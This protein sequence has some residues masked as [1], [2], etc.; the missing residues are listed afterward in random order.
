MAG[1]IRDKDGPASTHG[2]LEINIMEAS[3]A[4]ALMPPIGAGRHWSFVAGSY[5]IPRHSGTRT[6]RNLSVSSDSAE[7]TLLPEFVGPGLGQLEVRNLSGKVS[8]FRYS[9]G[10]RLFTVPSSATT[11]VMHEML[12]EHFQPP[13][14]C[15]VFFPVAEGLGE[16]VEP[17]SYHVI[18]S[19]HALRTLEPGEVMEA[20]L[21]Y[22]RCYLCQDFR[23][24]VVDGSDPDAMP[25]EACSWMEWLCASCLMRTAVEGSGFFV[26]CVLCLAYPDDTLEGQRVRTQLSAL[27]PSQRAWLENFRR[28]LPEDY[29]DD[30]E[31]EEV[32]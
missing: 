19:P 17:C 25:C 29:K 9:S 2:F 6:S 20:G 3:G 5:S 27:S 31:D 14:S 7:S 28:W 16:G 1:S 30:P 18:E 32:D 22:R 15:M 4:A 11:F 21:S 10:E 12:R 23:A 26:H 24:D 13:V 8:E